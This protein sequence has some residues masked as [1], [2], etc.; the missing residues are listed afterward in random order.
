MRVLGER[1]FPNPHVIHPIDP[2]MTLAD[3]NY[4]NTLYQYRCVVEHVYG[5]VA[6]WK[7]ADET[8]VQDVDLQTFALMVIYQIEARKIQHSPLRNWN[9][10]KR[11]PI[12]IVNKDMLKKH[13]D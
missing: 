8:F 11:V 12:R 7:L 1:G 4:N 3:C 9:L 13:Y 6:N 5:N 10:P 2:E